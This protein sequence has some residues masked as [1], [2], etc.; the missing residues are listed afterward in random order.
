MCTWV[1]N[2]PRR[3]KNLAGTRSGKLTVLNDTKKENGYRFWKCLCD[4]GNSLYINSRSLVGKIRT[5]TCGCFYRTRLLGKKFDE[6]EVLSCS[7]ND[8]FGHIMYECRCSCGTI[9]SITADNLERKMSR[10]CGCKMVEFAGDVFEERYG[11]RSI[12]GT[13]RFVEKAKK[14]IME[15]YGVEHATQNADV[16]AKMRATN[17]KRYGVPYTSQCPEIARKIAQG[18]RANVFHLKHWLSNED[19]SCQGSYEKAV[20]EYLNRDKIDYLWQVQTFTMPS[21]K[22]YRPDLYLVEDDKWVEI[23]G[24]FWG[25]A[26]YK[27]NWFKSEYPESEL[28]N[29]EVLKERGII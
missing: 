2:M 9:S 7:G 25:D 3:Y 12:F 6:W 4:C 18:V 27:W 5:Q 28:W 13:P 8:K 14:T 22:T 1:K 23:K 17:I 19:I 29:K 11:V 15:K 20:V 16:Q 26:L 21:G 10:S 24:Y